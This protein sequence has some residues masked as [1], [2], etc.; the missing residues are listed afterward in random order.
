[1]RDVWINGDG[2]VESNNLRQH[3]LPTFAD[4]PRSEVYFITT[5]DTAGP[6]GI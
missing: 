3:H 4:V 5:H 6:P 2:A 1:M